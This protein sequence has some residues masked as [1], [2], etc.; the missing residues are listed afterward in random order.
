MFDKDKSGRLSANEIYKIFKTFGNKQT[1]QEIEIMIKSIDQDEDGEIDF[2]EFCQLVKQKDEPPKKLRAKRP[3]KAEGEEGPSEAEKE[4]LDSI[5]KYRE[6]PESFKPLLKNM[7]TGMKQ[8]NNKDPMIPE[9][10]VLKGELHTFQGVPPLKYS[11]ELSAAAKNYL[12]KCKGKPP[13]NTLLVKEE[14]KLF[15]F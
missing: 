10:K 4:V 7:L 11:A 1:K 6:S 5:N 3:P 8:L 13:K 9:Y 14:C 12:E 15:L 2:P